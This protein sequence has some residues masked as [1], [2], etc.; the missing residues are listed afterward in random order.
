MPVPFG[1]AVKC[2]QVLLT[3]GDSNIY[4]P[5]CELKPSIY[6]RSNHYLCFHHLVA[7]QLSMIS[8][9][10][11]DKSKARDAKQ[12][13]YHILKSWMTSDDILTI[14]EFHNAYN[15]CMQWLDNLLEDPDTATIGQ[16]FKEFLLKSIYPRLHKILFL[17]RRGR[18]LEETTTNLAEVANA[19]MK[20]GMGGVKPNMSLYTSACTISKQ[21]FDRDVKKRKE[22]Q[23]RTN[24]HN[25]WSIS[26][27]ANV[28]TQFAE[29]LIM[30]QTLLSDHYSVLQTKSR[31]WSVTPHGNS[32]KD[33]VHQIDF[34]ANQHDSGGT[35]SGNTLVGYLLCSCRYFERMGLPCRHIIS[36]VKEV[37]PYHCDLRWNKE[38]FHFQRVEEVTFLVKEFFKL[39][40]MQGPEV[41][42]ND[43]QCYL[44]LFPS[45][46]HPSAISETEYLLD[47]QND[48]DKDNCID[49][50]L[51]NYVLELGGLSQET[52]LSNAHFLTSG[53]QRDSY[54]ANFPIF[55]ECASI[56]DCDK[57]LFHEMSETMQSMYKSLNQKLRM[58]GECIVAGQGIKLISSNV[59]LETH[60]SMRKCKRKRSFFESKK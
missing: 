54:S 31:S 48:D 42:L 24:G 4:E 39:P 43:I 10:H 3:D 58:K 5:F 34:V 53:D 23:R 50:C 16:S 18:F 6:P 15:K 11:G 33:H 57:E 46:Y 55:K 28:V 13:F 2:N 32:H 19:S 1:D 35:N 38:L 20:R 30:N 60:Q 47:D 56:A 40:P 49:L 52:S 25:N 27:T 37:Q 17:Y 12:Q 9:A 44:K 22:L 14:K 59:A 51:P 45:A 21:A 8:I 29:S 41:T 36:L 7:K 26:K